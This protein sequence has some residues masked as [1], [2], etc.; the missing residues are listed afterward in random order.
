MELVFVESS[1]GGVGAVVLVVVFLN[2]QIVEW[3]DGGDVDLSNRR[4]FE[5][6]S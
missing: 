4:I 2:Y 6:W 3:W 5:W 1:N